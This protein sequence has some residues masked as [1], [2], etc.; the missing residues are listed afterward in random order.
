M[1]KA[2]SSGVRSIERKEQECILHKTRD[3]KCI[4]YRIQAQEQWRLVL[5]RLG[6][7]GRRT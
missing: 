4:M 2:Q 5:H 6:G 1:H 7:G 3:H